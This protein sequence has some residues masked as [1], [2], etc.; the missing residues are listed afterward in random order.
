MN[1][2]KTFEKLL[3]D[4]L[5][6]VIEQAKKNLEENK[7]DPSFLIKNLSE[8]LIQYLKNHREQS[9]EY[10]LLL[11]N[12]SIQLIINQL[13]NGIYDKT[14]L[15]QCLDTPGS[16]NYLSTHIGMQYCIEEIEKR[17]SEKEQKLALNNPPKDTDTAPLAKKL[18]KK[19]SRTLFQKV[20]YKT[21]GSVATKEIVQN[22][23]GIWKKG[24]PLRF[25]NLVRE[26][27]DIIRTNKEKYCLNRINPFFIEE[28]MF[29]LTP[30]SEDIQEIAVLPLNFSQREPLKI[31]FWTKSLNKITNYWKKEKELKK[32]ITLVNM[33]NSLVFKE[34][35]PL[36]QVQLDKIIEDISRIGLLGEKL[37]GRNKLYKDYKDI[38]KKKNM[39]DYP[40]EIQKD[41]KI[42]DYFIIEL[43]KMLDIYNG[44]KDKVKLGL[45]GLKYEK[46]HLGRNLA[47]LWEIYSLNILPILL[48]IEE[49]IQKQ[50]DE[51]LSPLYQ[52]L[53]TKLL[54]Q[55]K[56]IKIECQGYLIAAKKMGI[57]AE[58]KYIP[59]PNNSEITFNKIQFHTAYFELKHNFS[60]YKKEKEKY[61]NMI[62]KELDLF[63]KKLNKIFKE[64]NIIISTQTL[65]LISLRS[66][67][68]PTPSSSSK[69]LNFFQDRKMDKLGYTP[70]L[71]NSGKMP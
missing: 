16:K 8:E 10:Y 62:H 50:A 33:I 41:A 51:V 21:K 24:N 18:N 68:S 49:I 20:S 22:M 60:Q 45:G 5:L 9:D 40:T 6:D 52:E 44:K 3:R 34:P 53:Y 35:S 57:H 37:Q 58:F 42:F 69:K 7:P 65:P 67:Q 11:F 15:D 1:W 30:L 39:D 59:Q 4:I 43:K 71:P 13:N 48:H 23:Y 54:P 28:L 64:E 70:E 25:N 46:A 29:R 66:S 32:Y 12:S 2:N 38:T 47:L 56:T 31:Q 27:Q 61:E 17:I 19:N 55:L 26:Y 14:I 63:M 36:T